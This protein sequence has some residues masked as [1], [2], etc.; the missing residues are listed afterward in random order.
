MIKKFQGTGDLSVMPER[1]RKSVG[2]ESVEQIA[3]AVIEIASSSIYSSASGRSM[4]RELEI[5]WSS[6]RKILRYILKW[7]PYNIPVMQT[8][9]PQDQ[10]I[11]VI[12]SYSCDT[13]RPL[14]EE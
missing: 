5:P 2:T 6:L 13:D 10:K 7:Y 1:G 4:S 11:R 3:T 8:L 14:A 12:I 9:K